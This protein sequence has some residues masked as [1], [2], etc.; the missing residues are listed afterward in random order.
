[1]AIPFQSARTTGDTGAMDVFVTGG[2]GFLGQQLVR[3]LTAQGHLVRALARSTE[4]THAV[5]AAGAQP[6]P[7][8]LA[9]LT[10]MAQGA[11]GC[12]VVVHA[13]A[14]TKQWGAKDR[15]HEINV[16]GTE[17]L[18]AASRAAGVPRLVHVSS[19]AVLADGRPLVDVDE[20]YP[21][22]AN[23]VGEYPRTKAIAE[24]LVLAANGDGL[25]TVVV[26]PRLLWGPGDTTIVPE[27]VKAAR[28]GRFAWIDGGRYLTSTCH[29]VNA[30]EGIIA[31]IDRGAPG[32][33]YFLTDGPPIE[34]RGFLTQ[35]AATA[36]ADLGDRSIPRWLAAVLAVTAETSWRLLRLSGEPPITRTFLALSGQQMTVRDDRAR[37]ELGYQGTVDRA[38][39]LAELAAQTPL[40]S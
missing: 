9:D 12:D 21:R 26:R 18:L 5:L 1:M 20:N 4:A 3:Q 14:Y 16:A 2:S 13:A 25:S 38:E 28:A 39:A 40:A 15:F 29:I 10:T 30:C 24:E 22:P 17:R 33:V 37:H 36:G 23:P 32:R 19:E 8:D 34:V 7:G 35:L 6:V 11:R 27:L 31:A